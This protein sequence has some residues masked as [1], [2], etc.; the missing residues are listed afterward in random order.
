MAFYGFLM[1][2]VCTA[3]YSNQFWWDGGIRRFAWGLSSQFLSSIED[4]SW[5][6]PK[7]PHLC[8]FCQFVQLN[9][10]HDPRID[11]SSRCW[12]PTKKSH[13][14]KC[15]CQRTENCGQPTTAVSLKK[16]FTVEWRK[17]VA[18]LKQSMPQCCQRLHPQLVVFKEQRSSPLCEML[19][20]EI[21]ESACPAPAKNNFNIF[22]RWSACFEKTERKG[23]STS[24]NEM[25]PKPTRNANLAKFSR[26]NFAQFGLQKCAFRYGDKITAKITFFENYVVFRSTVPGPP[27]CFCSGRYGYIMV[28]P[29]ILLS[30]LIDVTNHVFA[31]QMIGLYLDWDI[32]Q[33]LLNVPLG[34]AEH[35]FQVSVLDYV[36]CSFFLRWCSLRSC[37]NPCLSLYHCHIIGIEDHWDLLAYHW[38]GR[39]HQGGRWQR[40]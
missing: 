27:G 38:D 16:L 9:C 35:H 23:L 25:A 24:S 7:S 34:D 32:Y 15:F 29:Q 40:A 11:F 5:D 19:A 4:F 2:K 6:V 31:I 12:D 1:L 21:C 10:L 3:T 8:S 26:E 20:V 22:Q 14:I 39:S 28:Y 30:N 13:H 18:T 33:R 17:S 37:I 36:M